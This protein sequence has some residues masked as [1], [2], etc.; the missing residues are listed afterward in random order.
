VTAEA[1]TG[2]RQIDGLIDALIDGKA[3]KLD[4]TTLKRNDLKIAI[5]EAIDVNRD[6]VGY[7]N[8]LNNFL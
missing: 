8:W 1:K 7:E 6:E 4:G 2:N 3:K 5:N